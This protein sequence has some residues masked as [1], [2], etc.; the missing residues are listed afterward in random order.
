MPSSWVDSRC[1]SA[2]AYV[3]QHATRPPTRLQ[4]CA[5]KCLHDDSPLLGDP[6]WL[7]QGWACSLWVYSNY[8]EMAVGD[9]V[10]PGALCSCWVGLRWAC[11]VLGLWIS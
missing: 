9:L 5:L 6:Q 3:C 8:S 1:R 7:A 4:D 11:A 2:A 10:I